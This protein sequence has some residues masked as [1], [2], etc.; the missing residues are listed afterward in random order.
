MSISERVKRGLASDA[1]MARMAEE[2]QA[3]K[4]KYGEDK[5]YDLTLDNPMIEP[6]RAFDAELK[7]LIA[8]PRPGL[9]RYMENAGYT[10]TRTAIAAKLTEE[11]GLKFTMGEVIMTSGATGAINMAIKAVLNA[12]EEIII[13]S[14]YFFDYAAY[15]ENHAGIMKVVPSDANYVPDLKA[16]EAAITAKT[17]IIIINSPNN[18]T[19]AV[20]S[21]NV[22]KQIADIV[23]RR[24]AELKTRIYIVSDDSYRQFYYGAGRC[25]WVLNYYPHTIIV[26]SY[27]KELSL[28]GERIGYTAISPNCE[29]AKIVVG[30]L[31][32]AN[33][34]L[35]FV[36]APGLMQNV[37]RG[38]TAQA[39]NVAEYRQ[40]RD[41]LYEHLT[42]LGY[43]L[44]KPEGAFYLF[45]QVPVK[46]DFAFVNE[47]KKMHV[48][49]VPGT[50]FQSPGHIRVSYCVNDR[51]LQGSL[52][53]FQ[54]VREMYTANK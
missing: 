4:K 35:G 51:T 12:G 22:L 48:L 54:K 34:T 18:P 20:Y 15:I 45:P 10:D 23:T 53:G 16:L 39:I 14:P 26:S 8:T 42:R 43:S 7:K 19:G 52:A 5:V 40:K 36:N 2:G 44:V 49:T 1:F 33:R 27:S 17:K 21:E 24:S 11:T 25:P 29:D 32:H 31:I 30:G 38:L 46:D 28:P 13:F 9:H 37:V 41:F 3:L 50:L 6:P 47:L